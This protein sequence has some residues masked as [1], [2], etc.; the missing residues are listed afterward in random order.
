MEA[1]TSDSI[2]L[3]VNDQGHS[4]GLEEVME[5]GSVGNDIVSLPKN[6]VLYPELLGAAP[7]PVARV[8]VLSNAEEK[9]EGDICQMSCGLVKWIGGCGSCLSAVVR[10]I[11]RDG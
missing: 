5:G 11:D 2:L 9:V 8:G 7:L 4:G 3:V 10:H 1:L 6:D